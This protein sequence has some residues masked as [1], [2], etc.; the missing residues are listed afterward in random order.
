MAAYITSGTTEASGDDFTL[1]AGDSATLFLIDGGGDAVNHGSRADI[2]IK[3]SA[4]EYFTI[5][6]L[7][8]Q[9]GQNA[10]VIVAAGTYRV[11][12]RASTTAFGVDKV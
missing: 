6:S 11:V 4:G 7:S 10:R 12:R 8:G 3:S 2:Q 9:P 5:F 1:E